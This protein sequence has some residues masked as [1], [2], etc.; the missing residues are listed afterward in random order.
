MGAETSKTIRKEYFTGEERQRVLRTIQKLAKGGDTVAIAALEKYISSHLNA[1]MTTKF[2][3]IL[4]KN[5]SVPS[6][7]CSAVVDSLGPLLKGS[8]EEHL[9]LTLT[10]AGGGQE[11]VDCDRIIKYT[12]VIVCAYLRM[13]TSQ[14]GYRGWKSSASTEAAVSQAL[15][16]DLMHAGESPKEVWGKPPPKVRFSYDNFEK[17]C[18]GHSIFTTLE[19]EVLKNCFSLS[20]IDYNALMP[21][22]TQLPKSFPCMLTAAQVLFLNNALP[23]LMQSEWRFLFSTVTHG[24]SFSIFMKQIMGKGPTLIIVEDQSRNKFGGFAAVS[25]EVRPQFQGTPECFLFALEPQAGI[26]HSTGYN[27]NFMYLN[28]LEK[29][30]MP[31]GLG[32]GGREELFG[33]W[34]DYDFGKGSVAPSCSTFRSPS[35]SPHQKLEVRGIEVWALG[36]EEE[37][38]DEEEGT[39]KKKSALDAH[40]EARAML[41]IMGKE[42]VSEGLREKPDDSD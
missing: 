32:M 29:N 14:P 37:D 10:L 26:F 31:N 34:L 17:W 40:P 22:P 6:L 5:R 1:E 4:T 36:P 23:P 39:R 41:D 19:T 24:W 21:Q 35:L 9:F 38:S 33:F 8:M 16:H 7:P 27:K 11:G 15:L 42:R 20:P 18:L 12:E 25:W 30:T 2:V 3:G 13:I 28:Y